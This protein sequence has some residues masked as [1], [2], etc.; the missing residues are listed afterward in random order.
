M[1]CLVS[2]RDWK[3]DLGSY[4]I[5]ALALEVIGIGLIMPANFNLIMGMSAKGSEGV[6]NS[7]V[8][9]MRNVGAVMGIALF[10]SV[11]LSVIASEGVSLAGITAHALPPKAFVLG[12]HAI[13][14][15][16]AGLGGVLLALNLALRE[17]QKGSKTR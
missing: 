8:T 15:F 2:S 14:L 16:G 7:L 11:F 9:T 3:N 12:F 5:I 13:F 10:A 17:K 6:M 1:M 4:I